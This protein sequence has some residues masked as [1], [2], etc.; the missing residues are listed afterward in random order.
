MWALDLTVQ[1]DKEKL[2][3]LTN[4]A[5]VVVQA[6]RQGSL[7]RKGFG[8]DTILEMARRR[9]KGIVHVD[10]NCY[11]PDGYYAN[12]PDFQQIA[13][14]AS[15][16]CYVVGKA[17]GFPERTGV[18]PSLPIADML[19]GAVGFIDILL[20]L[21]VR[22]LE[23]GSY[24]APVALT[25]VDTIQLNKEVGLYP[26]ET[27]RKI[28]DKYQ[29]GKMIPDLH[30]EELL[31]VLGEAWMKKSDLLTRKGYMV[32]FPETAWDENHVI[33]SPIMKFEN[34]TA[35]PRW[36]HGPVPYFLHKVTPWA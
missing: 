12:R 29:F 3:S 9:K 36:Y 31:Y 33:L 1:G 5:N 22:A 18:L 11:G 8:L 26:P 6:F 20:D 30:V 24:H 23:G 14:A 28:Q 27:A 7:D 10:L 4:D 34:D 19:P 16:C 32:N 21:R 35:S 15:G 17:Y 13:D 2:Q 25:S